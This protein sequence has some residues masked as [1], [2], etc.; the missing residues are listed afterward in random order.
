[1]DK[2]RSLLLVILVISMV[3]T[4]VELLLLEHIESTWQ[5]L[6]IVLLGLG[7][8]ASLLVAIWPNRQVFAIFQLIM[9]A[10][11]ISGVVGIWLH[12][13]GNAEFELEMNAA[14]K[15]FELFRDSMMGATPAL[16]PGSMTQLGLLGLAYTYR[17]P[18]L[19]PAG[20]RRQS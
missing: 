5:W 1:M 15:G 11:V 18:R 6:P 7:V 10:C 12:Y 19:R 2:L 9:A 14:L 8:L 3:A 16:A 13:S 20:A 17:H 4:G